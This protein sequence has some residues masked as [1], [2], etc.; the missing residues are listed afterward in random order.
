MDEVYGK[1]LYGYT[2]SKRKKIAP[3]KSLHSPNSEEGKLETAIAARKVIN[4]HR[5]VLIALRDR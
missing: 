1:K 5:K 3:S 4:Q 2:M